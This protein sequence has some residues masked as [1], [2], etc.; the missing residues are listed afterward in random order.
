LNEIIE[1]LAAVLSM[2]KDEI[3]QILDA[4]RVPAS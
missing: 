1:E 3:Q 2:V 4:D